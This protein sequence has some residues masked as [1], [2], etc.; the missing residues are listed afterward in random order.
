MTRAEVP[1]LRSAH[2]DESLCAEPVFARWWRDAA[3]RHPPQFTCELFQ[4]LL[5]CNL[6]LEISHH[7]NRNFRIPR[8]QLTQRIVLPLPSP[9]APPASPCVSF[10]NYAIHENSR[11]QKP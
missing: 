1:A 11:G 4:R 9:H 5:T 3:L 6:T 10:E 8:R 2:K 7:I